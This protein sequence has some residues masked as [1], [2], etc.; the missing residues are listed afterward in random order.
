MK[1]KAHAGT[2]ILATLRWPDS[3]RSPSRFYF[4][5]IIIPARGQMFVEGKAPVS[6][7]Q[8][9]AQGVTDAQNEA[10]ARASG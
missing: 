5:E 1:V 4:H 7:M 8:E 2:E 9:V 3:Q 6:I 10:L